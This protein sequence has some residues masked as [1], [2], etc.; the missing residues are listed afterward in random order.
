MVKRFFYML[1]LAFVLQMSA[2]VASAYCMHET[3]QASKHFGH[4]QHTHQ[5]ADGDEDG[6]APAKKA[7]SDPD[8]AS[9]SHGTLVMLS[10]SSKV[11][12]LLLP[13]HQLLAQLPWQ[14]TPYLG[15]PERPNWIRAA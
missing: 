10:W 2:G 8:C 6:S 4:H 11:A 3:G 12:Q 14:P 5:N 15:L 7:G 13:A 1:A 9:C